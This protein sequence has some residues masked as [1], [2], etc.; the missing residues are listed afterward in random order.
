MLVSL[1]HNVVLVSLFLTRPVFEFV[2]A[3]AVAAVM[4]MGVFVIAVA[5]VAAVV[6][7]RIRTHR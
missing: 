6:T 5:V 1:L 7:A 3:V 2:I 4:V